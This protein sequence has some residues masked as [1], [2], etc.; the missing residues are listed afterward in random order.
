MFSEY[1]ISILV[2]PPISF[3]MATRAE[4]M[5]WLK[6]MSVVALGMITATRIGLAVAA[7][8]AAGAQAD[9]S[10]VSAIKTEKT[11]INELFF[12]IFSPYL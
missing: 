4:Y 6:A 12:F 3:W 5:D 9:S 10:N 2:S 8:A 7:G 11:I 1:L